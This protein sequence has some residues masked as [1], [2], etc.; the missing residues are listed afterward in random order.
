LKVV[1]NFTQAL[2]LGIHAA[3]LAR[4]GLACRAQTG[5]DTGRFLSGARVT[6][7]SSN[8]SSSAICFRIATARVLEHPLDLVDKFGR[9]LLAVLHLRRQATLVLLERRNLEIG[10]A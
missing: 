9:L 8:C 7:R 2:D 10:V 6:S 5:F 4:G 3:G 1:G